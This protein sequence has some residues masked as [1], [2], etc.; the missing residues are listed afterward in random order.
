MLTNQTTTATK[1]CDGCGK[2]FTPPKLKRSIMS[3]THCKDC[4]RRQDIYDAGQQVIK[5]LEHLWELIHE[6][7]V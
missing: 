1:K 3:C 5:G 4:R 7:F 6:K 2:D